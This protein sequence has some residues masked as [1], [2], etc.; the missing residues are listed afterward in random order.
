MDATSPARKPRTRKLPRAEDEHAA[1]KRP[2]AP[3]VPQRKVVFDSKT[4]QRMDGE[5]FDNKPNGQVEVTG[6]LG[7]WEHGNIV[8][9][10]GHFH[11]GQLHGL[12][13]WWRDDGTTFETYYVHGVAQS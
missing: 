13:T 6:K 3:R 2:R 7:T 10:K 4:G 9:C 1:V 8:A 12:A 11:D 5:F